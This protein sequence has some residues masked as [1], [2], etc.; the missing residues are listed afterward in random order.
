MEKIMNKVLIFIIAAL[1]IITLGYVADAK[2]HN[3]NFIEELNT[4]AVS[5]SSA[6]LLPEERNQRFRMLL[7]KNFDIPRIARFATGRYWRKFAPE[8][9]AEFIQ[10]FEEIIITKYSKLFSAYAGFQFVVIKEQENSKY[11]MVTSELRPGNEKSIVLVWQILVKNGQQKVVDIRVE[12][13]SMAITQ[14]EEYTS[15]LSNNK[16][17]IEALFKAM[18]NMIA[19]QKRR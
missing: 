18:R 19:N 15:I 17:D 7:K 2:T 12:G 3:K 1:V 16:I 10:L 9:K 13:V 5:L 11:A 8:Q 6:T 14:R 4:K